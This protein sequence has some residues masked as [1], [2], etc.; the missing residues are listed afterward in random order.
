MGCSRHDLT[1]YLWHEGCPRSPYGCWRGD[2]VYVIASGP[3]LT[4]EDARKAR[5]AQ[6]RVIAVNCSVRLC[7]DADALYAGDHKWWAHYRDDWQGFRGLKFSINA[8]A[9]DEFGVIHVER[10]KG[11][12]GKLG[13]SA[14]NNSGHQ[15]VNLAYLLGAS[16]IVMLGFDMKSS[17]RANHW[18]RDH[19]GTGMTNPNKRNFRDWSEAFT[20]MHEKLQAEGV[21]LWNATRDTALTIPERSLEDCLT[22]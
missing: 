2:R 17:G 12:L 4:E 14:S 8:Q 22:D 13:V 11:D 19:T 6:G 1:A 3:S 21:D 9:A 20:R 15:A 10:E 16:S 7:P 18:H 5:Q